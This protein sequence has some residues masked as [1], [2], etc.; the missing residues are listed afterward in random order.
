MRAAVNDPIQM[1]VSRMLH[2]HEWLHIA[3][4]IPLH[5]KT[6]TYHGRERRPNLV[7]GNEPDK[8]WAYCQACKCGAVHEKE[9]VRLTGESPEKHRSD[10]TI[11]ND[12]VD[13]RTSEALTAGVGAYLAGKGM[14]FKYLPNV[15]YS[16]S[17]RRILLLEH[18]QFWFG[19]DI[20]DTAKQKWLSYSGAQFVQLSTGHRYAVVTEDLFSAHKVEHVRQQQDMPVDVLCALGTGTHQY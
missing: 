20:T 7:I 11:P 4:R 15:L 14:D 9:H 18:G 3:Q 10:L 13:P 17:R 8:Y 12:L 19:R 1:E 6:R 2:Q 5:S 16:A